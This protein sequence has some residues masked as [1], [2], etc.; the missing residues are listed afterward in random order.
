MFTARR[1]PHCLAAKTPVEDHPAPPRTACN[2]CAYVDF[3]IAGFGGIAGELRRLAAFD[4]RHAAFGSARHRLLAD[5]R[6]ARATA[7]REAR[8]QVLARGNGAQHQGAGSSS[9]RVRDARVIG[10]VW[11]PVSATVV[12]HGVNIYAGVAL[13]HIIRL[14]EAIMCVGAG[15]SVER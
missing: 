14:A 13:C 1:R 15:F 4:T 5:A 9:A 2:S 10:A 7:R 6:R 8:R 11:S 12:R 3:D